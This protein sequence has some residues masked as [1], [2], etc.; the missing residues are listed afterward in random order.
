MHTIQYIATQ[1]DDVDHAFRSV[2]DYLENKMGDEYNLSSWYDWFVTGGGR[3]ASNDDPYDDSFTGDVVHQDDPKFHDYLLKAH[4]YHM[5][6]LAAVVDRSREINLTEILDDIDMNKEGMYPHMTA[7]VHLYPLS[8]L[9]DMVSG[10]W[11]YYSY[12][13]D[14]I[15]EISYPTILRESIDKG[16]DNWYIVPVDFHF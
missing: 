7:S 4:E 5:A 6:D 16:V 8:K 2:K 3:W 14:I 1:A 10:Q 15:N 13:F 11:S 9:H 12:F